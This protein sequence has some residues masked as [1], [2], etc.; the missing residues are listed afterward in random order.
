MTFGFPVA[1]A[2]DPRAKSHRNPLRVELPTDRA[3]CRVDVLEQL[4]D[5][6]GHD[7]RE[8][9]EDRARLVNGVGL[10]APQ[11]V[12]LPD[13]IDQLVDTSIDPGHLL[14]VAACR[15]T[16]LGQDRNLGELVEDRPPRGLGRGV[17]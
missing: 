7:L 8:E 9:V 14:L 2:A 15:G 12:G 1:V 4:G 11:L 6:F 5:A 17:R 13:R 16:L 10:L 3:Q